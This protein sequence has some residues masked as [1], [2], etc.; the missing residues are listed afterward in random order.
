[1][2]ATAIASDSIVVGLP[3]RGRQRP[4]TEDVMGLFINLLP[5]QFAVDA[6][7]T[8]GGFLDA[9]RRDTVEVFEN[10]EVPFERIAEEP[11]ISAR[12]T[13]FGL[14]HALFSFQDARRRTRVWGGLKQENVLL[15]QKGSTE[16]LVGLWLMEVPGGLEG[17]FTYN[18]DIYLPETAQAMRTRYMELMQR[19]AASPSIALAELVDPAGSDAA[20]WLRRLAATEDERAEDAAAG[21]AIASVE[22]A[23]AA[24]A[25]A[26]SGLAT[27]NE[28]QLA[29]IWADLLDIDVAQVT[30]RDNFFDLGG[31]SLLAMRAIESAGRALGFRVDARRYYFESLG[32]LA[33]A[34]AA[35]TIASARPAPK[36]DEE[37]SGGG[38]LRKVF[39]AFGAK[40]K[41]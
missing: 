4:E 34:E 3:V 12:A 14:Y 31:H 10:Q 29:G 23:P 20:Q 32:Q 22:A 36:R 7:S 38:L 28:R 40:R 30:A 13:R 26:A 6:R 19:V 35:S 39:G 27:E 11:D 18:A 16:D 9:V 33:N 1:M 25:K 15:F 5:L 8:L 2:M 41:S 17:G 21:A 37:S 24:G